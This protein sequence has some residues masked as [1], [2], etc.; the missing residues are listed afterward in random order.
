M[1]HAQTMTRGHSDALC[2]GHSYGHS[3]LLAI[4]LLSGF[5]GLIYQSIWSHYLGLLLGHAAYAQALVLTIFMGGMAAGAAWI[6]RAGQRWRNLIRGYALVEG[7]IGILGI[8]FHQIFGAATHASYEWLIPAL[9]APEL[10][11]A[12]RWVVAALLILPQT[13]LLGMTFPLMSGGL[14]RRFPGADGQLLGGLYFTNSMGAAVGALVAVFVLLPWAGLPGA[15]AVAG[16]LNLVVAGL[17]WHLAREPE[18]AAPLGAQ[19]PVQPAQRLRQS[20][21]LRKVLLGTA[22]SGAASFAYEIVWVRMLSM[23]VGSTMHAFELMLASF[24]AGI[25]LGGLWVRGR[26]DA[27]ADPLRLVGWMQIAMGVAALASLAVYAQAFSWVG[28]L[29]QALGKTDGGYVL[30]NAGTAAVA[31][32][33]MF[34][35]AFFAGTTL[36]LFTVALLRAGHGERAIGRVYAWNTLGSIVGVLVAIHVLI[37]GVGLKLALCIAAGV[38]LLIGLLLLQGRTTERR[39][40]LPF[41]AAVALAACAFVLALR[42]PYD[43]RTVASGVFRHGDVRLSDSEQVLFYEDGRTA[44]VASTRSTNGQVQ[45]STNGKTDAAIQMREDRPASIDEPTMALAALLPLAMHAAPERAGVIGFGSGLTTHVLLGDARVKVVDTIEIESAMLRGARHFGHRV[46]RAF[47]DPRSHIVIDDAKAYF[48]GQNKKYDLIIS[49]PS[50]PWISGVGA[51]FSREFYEFVPRHLH[52]RGLFVQWVQL[53][54]MDE[55]LMGSILQALTPAFEDYGAWLSNHSDLLIVASPKGRLPALDLSS[56]Q[57]SAGSVADM[58]RLGL[59]RK[60]Q[61]AFRKIADAQF[62]RAFA[63]SHSSLS[64]NSDFHPV[65]NLEAP[66]TRFKNTSV[67]SLLELPVYNRPLLEALDISAPLPMQTPPTPGEY[68]AADQLTRRARTLVRELRGELTLHT[69]EVAAVHAAGRGCASVWSEGQIEQVVASV[70]L[71]ARRTIKFLPADA[72]DGAWIDAGWQA[73]AS[74]PPDL[75]RAFVL[76][77]AHARRDYARME[78]LGRDWVQHRPAQ[79]ALRTAFDGYAWSGAILAMVRDGRDA[80]LRAWLAAMDDSGFDD[81]EYA[82]LRRMAPGLVAHRAQPV[83]LEASA[84]TPP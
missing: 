24:I 32:A 15:M 48:S 26:A 67:T 78:A 10:V 54:E 69:R 70:S 60:E 76:L 3:A 13:V 34:P 75:R 80:Q 68:F 62:L 8:F 33:I 19:A 41:G 53:Y 30:F 73:C 71:L 65:L 44:S 18:P 79:Q 40:W 31:V 1:T 2:A 81:P 59:S 47:E 37:P 45:I 9:G 23:A 4:F 64:A 35:A 39:G 55:A 6:S 52:E 16:L 43:A 61:F 27:S 74:V 36:P 29:M 46:A 50:N 7:V 28:W 82:F 56:L 66:R 42:I 72:L 22:L 58:R 77:E 11:V 17:A 57:A 12:A 84:A 20:P 38:D 51:L 49:E 5:S 21:L 14:I 83:A 63:R 25:A